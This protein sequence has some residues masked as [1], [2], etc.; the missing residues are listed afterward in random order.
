[1]GILHR[2]RSA[3]VRI[4]V[5]IGFVA[6]LAVPGAVSSADAAQISIVALGA[7]NTDG[8]GV[9]RAEAYPAQLERILRDKG[10]DVSV[11]NAG[12]SGDT[13]EGMLNRLDSSVPEGTRLVILQPGNNDGRG[14]KRQG[15]RV[16]DPEAT[17]GNLESIVSRLQARGI[18]VAIFAGYHGVARDVAAHTHSVFLGGI[19]AG[20]PAAAIQP[21]GEHFLPEGYAIVAQRIAPRIVAMLGR[22]RH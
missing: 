2:G 21:D 16:I 8:K 22:G 1:M 15:Y 19:R 11:T 6:A 20:V 14:G 12:I 13:T 10:L 9:S 7:S 3:L 5:S 18:A 4:F 17:A